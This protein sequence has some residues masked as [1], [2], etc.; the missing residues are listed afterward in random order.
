LRRGLRVL[1]ETSGIDVVGEASD[2]LQ[3]LRSCSEHEPDAVVLDIEMP[4]LNGI[5]VCARLQSQRRPPGVAILSVHD[6]AWYIERAVEAGA[7]AYL[8]K[9]AAAD[10]LVPAVYAVGAGKTFLTSSVTAVLVHS[11]LRS[12]Q[13][14]LDPYTL[15]TGREKE[16]L[17]RL[18]EGHCNKE[19]ARLLDVAPATVE[20]HRGSLM[21]KLN[22]HSSAH[23]VLY[24]VRK[25]LVR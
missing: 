7:R 22:L 5:E 2:G 6:E 4:Q 14:D 21:R 17:H 8:L 1:L 20:A 16:V 3:A 11:Y 15:L 10:S 23:I 24:A 19:V 18:G 13:G 25:G 9:S 12:Q